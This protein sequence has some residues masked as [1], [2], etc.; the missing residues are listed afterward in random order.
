MSER[1]A[2]RALGQPRST[3]RYQRQP[4]A[5]EEALRAATVSLAERF[6]RYGYR[7]VTYLLREAGWEVNSKRVQRIWRE[8]GLKV[9]SRQPKRGRLWLTDGSCIRLRPEYPNHVWSYDF[10]VAS[11]HDGRRLRLLVVIDEFTRECL[12]IHVARH[13]TNQDVLYLLSGLFLEY[14][15]PEH[16]RSDNGPEFAAKAIR[17]WLFDLGVTTL[18]IEPGSPW[19]N[20]YVES[21]NGKLRDELLNG[22]VFYTLA[23]ARILI[24]R[25]RR[26]YNHLRPHSSL[27]GRPPAPKT[28]FWPG[29]SLEDF[30]PSYLTREPALSLS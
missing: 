21:F 10:L 11:T 18:F 22:E 5:D 2:C 23:E 19:E 6:G 27:G 30:G 29:F 3:Q 24:E 1:R 20:G 17:K 12:C 4:K 26:E 9:P 8:E 15:V 16:I 7:R 25:W 13:T 14:G 28:I